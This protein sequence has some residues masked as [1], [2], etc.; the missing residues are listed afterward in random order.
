MI[1]VKPFYLLLL[2]LF[3]WASLI[4]VDNLGVLN[5]PIG[6]QEKELLPTTIPPYSLFSEPNLINPEFLFFETA[7]PT[8]DYSFLEEL[9]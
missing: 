6:Q 2:V 7:L 4:A 9:W 8:T 3:A 5:A 1:Q